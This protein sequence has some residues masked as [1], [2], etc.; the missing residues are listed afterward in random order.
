MPLLSDFAKE[1]GF[2]VISDLK[3]HFSPFKGI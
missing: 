1:L 3:Y 2:G